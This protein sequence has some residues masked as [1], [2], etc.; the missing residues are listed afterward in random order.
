MSD[1]TSPAERF[2]RALGSDSTP[3]LPFF[4]AVRRASVSEGADHFELHA[5]SS[6][7]AT[8]LRDEQQWLNLRSA[9]VG[10]AKPVVV[11]EPSP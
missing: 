7:D 4:E 5:A 10:L 8:V 6:A 11:T 1:Q 9:D 3:G 2:L